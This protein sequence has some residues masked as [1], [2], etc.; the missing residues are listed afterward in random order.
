[1][2]QLDRARIGIGDV[3][4]NLS[5]ETKRL[6]ASFRAAQSLSRQYG[7]FTD[8]VSRLS[9]ID[10]DVIEAVIAAGLH[11]TDAGRD[12]LAEKIYT[13]KPATLVGPCIKYVSNLAN[14][15]QPIDINSTE[16]E[17]EDPNLMSS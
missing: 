10:F 12:G 3:E 4:I 1:M 16:L 17:D 9:K 15:G 6:K 11:L 13:N 8:I 5:G 7:G 2:T 14:G